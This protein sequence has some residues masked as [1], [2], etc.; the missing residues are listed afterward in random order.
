MK[1]AKIAY[2][3]AYAVCGIFEHYRSLQGG[4]LDDIISNLSFVKG[5]SDYNY[6]KNYLSDS[7][8]FHDY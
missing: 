7:C 3:T 2:F 6:E 1:F 8:G 4:N 5:F